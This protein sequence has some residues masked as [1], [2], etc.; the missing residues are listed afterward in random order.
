MAKPR[1]EASLRG[2][3][4]SE[5][6]EEVSGSVA[7]VPKE[8]DKDTQL[9]FALDLVR[10]KAPTPATEQEK[11]SNATAPERKTAN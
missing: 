10:G 4:Q 8:K 7:Y 5:D 1:G 6:G 3:L 2:H 11:A 9:Q